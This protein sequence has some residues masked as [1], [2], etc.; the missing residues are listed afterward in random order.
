MTTQALQQESIHFNG[1]YNSVSNR[2]LMFDLII[3]YLEFCENFEPIER[4]TKT[5][6]LNGSA[7]SVV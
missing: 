6:M 5:N 1:G 4:K 2:K 7:N 3:I